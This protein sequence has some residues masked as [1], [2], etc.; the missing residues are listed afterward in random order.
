MKMDDWEEEPEREEDIVNDN[1]DNRSHTSESSDMFTLQALLTPVD[2]GTESVEAMSSQDLIE[3]VSQREPGRIMEI[4]FD[5]CHIELF[6]LV[7]CSSMNHL[8]SLSLKG[9]GMDMLP[10]NFGDLKN[11]EK[12]DLN[13]NRLSSLPQ[14]MVHM[15]NL[16][17]LYIQSNSFQKFPDAVCSMKSLE[18]LMI[19]ENKLLE[20]PSD[21]GQLLCLRKVD[22]SF[23][24]LVSLPDSFGDLVNLEFLNLYQNK[25]KRLPA[26]FGL[27]QKLHTLDISENQLEALPGEFSSCETLVNFHV[28]SN[29]LNFLPEWIGNLPKLERLSLKRNF[30]RGEALPE[31]FGEI[32]KNLILF[33]IS[34]NF[35]EKLPE[36]FALLDKLQNVDIGSAE[37]EP[38]RNRNL[39][40]GNHISELPLEFGKFFKCM[41]ELRVDENLIEKLPECIGEMENLTYFDLYSNNLGELPNSFCKLKNMKICILS[42]N[43]LTRLP[44]NFGDLENLEELR[45]DSNDVST[46][47]YISII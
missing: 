31:S 39:K 8:K 41:T 28:D 27:I 3:K 22:L 44:E 25:L 18:I 47:Y 20:L 29:N 6:P 24:Y 16:K 10:E 17:E 12:L 1:G 14:S 30:V 46:I 40:Q 9:N 43:Y 21:I 36:S 37:F 38:E 35:F 42:M 34:G 5:Y 33:D 23:N 11:L 15:Q 45:L 19:S 32:N 13:E 2:G 26:S 7:F 4:T